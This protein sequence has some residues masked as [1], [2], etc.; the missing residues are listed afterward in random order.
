VLLSE[1][2]AVLLGLSESGFSNFIP[3]VPDSSS[4]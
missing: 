1:S 2:M 3:E 4:D